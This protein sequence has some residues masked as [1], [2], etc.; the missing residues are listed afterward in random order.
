MGNTN[1]GKSTFLNNLLG[2]N[3]LLNTSEMRETSTLWEIKF[4]SSANKMDY[5]ISES[6]MVSSQQFMSLKHLKE[7]ISTMKID[8]KGT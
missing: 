3:S 6:E 8:R 7:E 5:Y 4:S 2:V 1:A